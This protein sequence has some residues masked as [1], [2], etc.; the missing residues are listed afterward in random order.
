MAIYWF[1]QAKLVWS[2]QVVWDLHVWSI[3]CPSW[4]ISF[5]IPVLPISCLHSL[6]GRHNYSGWVGV[7]LVVKPNPSHAQKIKSMEVL[8]VKKKKEKSSVHT[9]EA[10]SLN[11]WMVFKYNDQTRDTHTSLA[12][13]GCY[14][15]AVI[16]FP[17]ILFSL[18]LVQHKIIM[19]FIIT[20]WIA[21][22]YD[23][24]YHLKFALA[25]CIS[26]IN[27]D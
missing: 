1:P 12:D 16:K 2:T 26:S 18:P 24:S 22:I 20:D 27:T 15:Y 8:S 7:W 13:H 17:V 10:S 14:C 19:I 11:I 9:Y 4:P 23:T 21:R 5:L 25:V 6:C 3:W